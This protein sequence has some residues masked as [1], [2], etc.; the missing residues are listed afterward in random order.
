MNFF[1][2]RRPQT[3]VTCCLRS[4]FFLQINVK[5]CSPEGAR[6]YVVPRAVILL[7]HGNSV[8]AA[9]NGNLR[10]LGIT[11]VTNFKKLGGIP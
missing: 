5:T 1:I 8:A 6:R 11:A 3:Q 7:P 10:T 4:G 2:N 9:V